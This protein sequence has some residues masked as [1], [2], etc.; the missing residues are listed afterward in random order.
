MKSYGVTIQMQVSEPFFP[1]V[2]FIML[3]KSVL[4]FETY[5]EILWR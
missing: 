4:P 1:V 3:Y 2:L 5:D